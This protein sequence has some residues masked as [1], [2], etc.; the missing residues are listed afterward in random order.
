MYQ[1][2]KI[3]FIFFKYDILD[4]LEMNSIVKLLDVN[5]DED[6]VMGLKIG[7]IIIKNYKDKNK[8]KKFF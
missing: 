5:E 7:D 1:L 2:H 8:M 4:I 3:I 6:I